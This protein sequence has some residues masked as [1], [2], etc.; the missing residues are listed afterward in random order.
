MKQQYF[1][2]VFLFPH[3]FGLKL[4]GADSSQDT[5]KP[6]TVVPSTHSGFGNQLG[7]I[8]GGAFVAK[9]TGCKLILPPI[10]N[11]GETKY[12]SGHCIPGDGMEKK[13]I[14]QANRYYHRHPNDQ[15]DQLFQYNL[16]IVF[17]DHFQESI[18]SLKRIPQH[19][20]MPHEM[21]LQKFEEYLK[22]YVSKTDPSGDYAMGSGFWGPWI[23]FNEV[24]RDLSEGAKKA[25]SV[26]Q[27][28]IAEQT[29]RPQGHY[30]CLHVR[31]RDKSNSIEGS[32]LGWIAG[33]LP[34]S[35][36]L[37][38]FLMS[39]GSHDQMA[40]VV[41]CGSKRKCIKSIDVMPSN[42]DSLG[43][44]KRLFV[45]LAVCGMATNVYL[46]NESPS[47]KIIGGQKQIVNAQYKQLLKTNTTF[48]TG[49]RRRKSSG[50]PMERAAASSSDQG[51]PTS[52]LSNVIFWITTL[53]SIQAMHRSRG[54]ATYQ[55]SLHFASTAMPDD[56][57][58]YLKSS[59]F[60]KSSVNA[61]AWE[62]EEHHVSEALIM[63]AVNM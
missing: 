56:L 47:M 49:G 20:G 11:H 2:F 29:G 46:P 17:P 57:D 40:N 30:S 27:A 39:Q 9:A 54:D 4:H 7:G 25:A 44:N 34:H 63:Q 21:G 3:F 18:S 32:T 24:F 22:D 28:K 42:A 59:T 31:T 10:L 53:P 1:A 16:E 26:V 58:N 15:Y 45:E 61:A 6:C 48:D 12:G 38:L 33:H 8:L 35:D 13:M 37:P 5:D 41:G 19:C 52:T 55:P 62:D 51:Y 14:S 36:D 50:I 60:H 43:S 23:E